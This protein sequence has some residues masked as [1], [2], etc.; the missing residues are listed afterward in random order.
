[1]GNALI[2]NQVLQRLGNINVGLGG[3][4][5]VKVDNLNLKIGGQGDGP[6]PKFLKALVK[7]NAGFNDVK[8]VIEDW[9][10]ANQGQHMA[11]AY[12]SNL[13]FYLHQ[14]FAPK[15][16]TQAIY[17]FYAD[18][19]DYTLTMEF[20]QPREDVKILSTT[21]INPSTT[22]QDIINVVDNSLR[23]GNYCN[24]VHI[25]F[26]DYLG[27]DVDPSKGPVTLVTVPAYTL[28][29]VIV[30]FNRI[31]KPTSLA[32]GVTL[33]NSEEDGEGE[34]EEEEEEVVE[35]GDVGTKTTGQSSSFRRV[36][37]KQT[38][39]LNQKN[40][41]NVGRNI[42][43]RMKKRKTIDSSRNT[44]SCTNTAGAT[45][46]QAHMINGQLFACT[47]DQAPITAESSAEAK[48]AAFEKMYVGLRRKKEMEDK[49]QRRDKLIQTLKSGMCC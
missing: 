2:I 42:L 48:V 1:M 16:V 23:L 32:F 8:K 27:Q 17:L 35:K 36:L 7:P 44:T 22:G 10:Q 38:Q 34:V 4:F 41:R 14:D 49:K 45:S 18:E 20:N 40:L 5:N 47:P 12:L 24:V 3:L 25:S 13:D 19:Y 46:T 9:A 26:D 15:Q 6:T 30:D 29:V 31:T 37:M 11:S 39:V 21:T 28:S 33:V 43:K